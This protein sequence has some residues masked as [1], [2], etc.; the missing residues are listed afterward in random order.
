LPGRLTNAGLACIVTG[1]T[2]CVHTNQHPPRP[3]VGREKDSSGAP[4]RDEQGGSNT[5]LRGVSALHV[6]ASRK[7]LGLGPF[8]RPLCS[9]LLL[10]RPGADSPEALCALVG[11]WEHHLAT[12][13][14]PALPS[15]HPRQPCC[16]SQRPASEGS[17]RIPK[18]RPMRSRIVSTPAHASSRHAEPCSSHR[19]ANITAALRYN[20]LS[21]SL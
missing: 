12:V 11:L 10:L 5:H 8:Q 13:A 9:L 21:A 4:V 1:F 16:A 17:N 7:H 15:R 6:T 18:P 19:D 20:P 2:G 14:Q 3:P